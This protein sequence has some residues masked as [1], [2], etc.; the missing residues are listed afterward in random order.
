MARFRWF[1]M[2]TV[3]LGW[4]G[5]APFCVWVKQ[6]ELDQASLG[7]CSGAGSSPGAG[8]HLHLGTDGGTVPQ[9]GNTQ[10]SC[11]QV[12]AG[13]CKPL[14][15]ACPRGG[16]WSWA[17]GRPLLLSVMDHTVRSRA[18][19]TPGQCWSVTSPPAEL[20]ALPVG[21]LPGQEITRSPTLR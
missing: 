13:D 21:F 15:R 9:E 18:A 14:R 6:T 20:E 16:A 19:G 12:R 3:V 11:R 17:D 2:V 5:K 7:F 4:L 8:I 1:H 10:K